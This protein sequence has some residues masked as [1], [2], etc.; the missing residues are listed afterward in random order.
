MEK[1]GAHEFLRLAKSC[2]V[3]DVRS[4]SEFRAGHIPGAMNIPLFDDRERDLVGKEYIQTGRNPAIIKGL[5]LAGPSFHVKLSQ[6]NEAAVNGRLLVHCWRGGMRSEAMAWLF[7]L[8]GI[9]CLVLEGGYK[10]YRHLVLDDLGKR[11]K[12]IILGGLTGSG[13]TEILKQL[14]STGQQVIDL[15]GIACHK[16]SAFGSL[17][18]PPQPSSEHFANIL[19]SRLNELDEE[20]PVWLEDESKNIGT[21]FMPDQ[22]YNIM[23]E[24]PVVAIMEDIETRM[25]RLLSEYSRYSPEDLEK[26]IMRIS[27]RL[28][29]DFTKEALESIRSGD[30]QRAIEITLVYYDK[31]YTFG[32]KRRPEGLIRYVSTDTHDVNVNS[33][34]VLE[35][36]SSVY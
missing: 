25:P 12:Y 21:V 30:F 17:G 35:A 3:V 19:H 6:A 5:E 29:G 33:A 20:K 15:E 22:F 31:T 16:G 32:L 1:T 27:K 4:P 11:R 14:A 7:S 9:D 10:A 28:G 24:S 2:P 23:Q 8:A 26:S 36:A 13:K 18:Q 34:R